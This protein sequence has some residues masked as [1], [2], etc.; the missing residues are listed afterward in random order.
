MSVPGARR[1]I[2]EAVLG[3]E[4]LVAQPHRCGGT[5]YLLG[6]RGSMGAHDA[7]LR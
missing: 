2:E 1:K 4:D 3:W 5:E 7:S 6:R